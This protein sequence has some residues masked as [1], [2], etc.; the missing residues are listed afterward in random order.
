MYARIVVRKPCYTLL[1][2]YAEDFLSISFGRCKEQSESMTQPE[3]ERKRGH[4][5]WKENRKGFMRDLHFRHIKEWKSNNTHLKRIW[6]LWNRSFGGVLCCRVAY[7]D[8]SVWTGYAIHCHVRCSRI[9]SMNNQWLPG[10]D[11]WQLGKTSY[12]DNTEATWEQTGA[13]NIELTVKFTVLRYWTS[14]YQAT[15]P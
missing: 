10:K 11:H 1:R 14:I 9:I 2:W 13:G 6:S 15:T 4:G 5:T 12:A 3:R 7:L 8:S